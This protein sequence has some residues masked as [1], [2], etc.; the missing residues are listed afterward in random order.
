MC[1]YLVQEGLVNDWYFV[2]L[3]SCVVGGVGLV[4]VEVIVVLFEGC[5]IVDDFGIWSDVYV[6]LLYCIICFI[7]FQG[8]VVGVQLVYV[9]CKVSIWW[10]WLGKYG[11]VLIGD[12]GWILVVLL[13][14][15]FDFQ[16][17]I[18]E[19]LSEVQIEVLVQVFVCVV[20]CFLVVGFKVV[21]VYVVYGYLL[22]QFFLLLLNQ[23]C[24]QYGGCFENCICLFLQVIV[25]VCKVWL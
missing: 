19:V 25:V 13:V 15:L 17:M 8:V 3:G 11:S 2:Y 12:G 24:D 6:E 1:Q 9:G 10:L 18:F 20:E 5:I 14:I 21:E 22:Y 16:Y 23:C 7:E 4:I